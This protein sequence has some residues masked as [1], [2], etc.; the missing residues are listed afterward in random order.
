MAYFQGVSG[1][2]DGMSQWRVLQDS[3]N[4]GCS[5]KVGVLRLGFQD[6]VQRVN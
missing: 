2:W 4:G 3:E 5:Q 1:L 6:Q